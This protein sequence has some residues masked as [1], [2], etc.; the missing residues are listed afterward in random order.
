MNLH[1][2]LS[3]NRQ[4]DG[5]ILNTKFIDEKN[6]NISKETFI[7][8]LKN[9]TLLKCF[10]KKKIPNKYYIMQNKLLSVQMHVNLTNKSKHCLKDII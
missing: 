6:K 2:K 5:D 1:K 9:N 8:D 4:T 7:I 10:T 3:A